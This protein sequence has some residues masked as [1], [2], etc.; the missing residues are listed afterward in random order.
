MR[1]RQR[2]H[3]G[4]MVLCLPLL[5][6]TDSGTPLAGYEL[7]GGVP[8]VYTYHAYESDGSLVVAGTLTMVSADSASI[9]GTWDLKQVHASDQIGPQVGSG[10]LAG[11]VHEGTIWVNLNPSWKDNNVFLQGTV[12]GDRISGNWSWSTFIG[13]TAGGTFEAVKK[14]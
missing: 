6:C 10:K 4:L 7:P 1:L 14:L 12:E 2:W 3:L 13:R 8:E 11:S 9:N 5:G